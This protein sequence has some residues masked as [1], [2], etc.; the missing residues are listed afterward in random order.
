MT[1]YKIIFNIIVVCFN[2]G[3]KLKSTL[4]SIYSQEYW[5]MKVIIKDGN[6]TDNS[7]I[8][9]IESNYFNGRID[10]CTQIE[11]TGDLGIYDAMNVATRFLSKDSNNEYTIFMNCGDSFADKQVLGRVADY[12]EDC[13]VDEKVPYIFYG[14]QYNLLTNTAVSSAPNI[15]DFTL[16]RNVPCHQVCFYDNRLFADRGYDIE[17]KVR[18]D[19]EHFLYCYYEK[20]AATKHM[21]ILISNYEGGGF[22]ET[23]ENRVLSAKE[24]KTI[25]D[26]YMGRKAYR[27]RLIMILTGAKIRTWLAESETFSGAYNSLKSYIY[28]LRR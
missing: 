3:D 5:G 17:Y 14:D 8:N 6:S 13:G 1:D 2:A 28:K 11:S 4:D 25:T 16:F 20:K 22:S 12:I 9:L 26:Y 10:D 23:K 7:L 24:H 15:N 18:A 19:Y 21:D 27:Y